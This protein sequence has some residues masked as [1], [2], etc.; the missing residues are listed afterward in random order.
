MGAEKS[1]EKDAKEWHARRRRRYPRASA[2]LQVVGGAVR[3]LAVRV[4]EDS[5]QGIIEGAT[6]LTAHSSSTDRRTEQSQG[7]S[8]R[9]TSHRSTQ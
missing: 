2:D 8:S 3:R 9:E 6:A 7:T 1:E 5:A 4:V